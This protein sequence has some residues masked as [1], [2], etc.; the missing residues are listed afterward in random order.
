[1]AIIAINQVTLPNLKH[2][3]IIT[4]AHCVTR[5][6]PNQTSFRGW[7]RGWK[8]IEQPWLTIRL[9]ELS[10]EVNSTDE[11]D[12]GVI[13]MQVHPGYE[14]KG[15]PFFIKDDVALITLDR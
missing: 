13:G 15:S 8:A 2:R 12:Y 4:A 9:G 7:T 5:L 3:H 14:I 1:M 10:F 11:K 6:L